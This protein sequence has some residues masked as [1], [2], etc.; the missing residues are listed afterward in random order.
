MRY[1]C[2]IK[3]AMIVADFDNESVCFATFSQPI[4]Y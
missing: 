1:L 3:R 2:C 4:F